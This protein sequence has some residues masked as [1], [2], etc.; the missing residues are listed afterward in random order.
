MTWGTPIT[1]QPSPSPQPILAVCEAPECK[2]VATLII[3]HGGEPHKSCAACATGVAVVAAVEGAPFDEAARDLLLKAWNDAKGVLE[4]AKES[5]MSIRK[6]VAAYVFP[7]PKEGVNNHELGGGYVLKMGHKLNYN[8]TAP[9]EAVDKAEDEAAK[10]G[11]EGTF[12]FERVITW[13]PNFSKSE[14]N[15]LDP[16]LPAHAGVKKLVD[17][18]LEIKPGTPSLEIK[19]PKAKLNG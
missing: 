17:G 18:L 3:E 4:R 12:L 8:I 14:Y 13:T 7:T 5:E 15:K 16:A 6:A 10:L 19:E 2:N 9:N 11:N 1:A